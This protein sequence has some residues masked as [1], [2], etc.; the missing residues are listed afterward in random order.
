[1]YESG[2]IR[3]TSWRTITVISREILVAWTTV[4]ERGMVRI[5]PIRTFFNG[6]TICRV[7]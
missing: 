3:E 5:G 7:C 2:Q 4:V 1:M 6:R